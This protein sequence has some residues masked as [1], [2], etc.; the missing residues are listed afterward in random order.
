MTMKPDAVSNNNSRMG[1]WKKIFWSLGAATG[2]LAAGLGAGAS[3][4]A[5]AAQDSDFRS[6]SKAP[7]SWQEFAKQL[8]DRFQQRL[9]SAD[10]QA[11]NFQHYMAK[12]G[13]A[14]ST[15]SLTLVV[16]AWV[17]PG[18]QVERL[19]FDGLNDDAVAVDLRAL[20]ARGDVGAPP[21][22]MLQPLHL[23]LSLRPEDQPG[24]EQ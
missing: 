9:A 6:A 21:P 23:R 19:E 18:G 10:E 1:W 12:R 3:S 4:V 5:A 22:D 7:V 15:T 8:Q 14:S 24:Q 11:R 16:R 20:L 17:L 13:K 2:L